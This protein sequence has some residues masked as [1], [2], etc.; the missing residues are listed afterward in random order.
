MLINASE[1][2]TPLNR[3][4][5]SKRK[6]VG[7][8][9]R[10]DIVETLGKYTDNDYARVFDNEHFYF[11]KQAIMLTNIDVNG[12]TF[13]AH[14]PF[15]E[16]KKTGEM[17]RITSVALTPSKISNG[18][19]EL[20]EFVISEFDESQYD[21][22]FDY[23]DQDIKPFVSSLDYIEQP[24]KVTTSEGC[25][26][27]DEDQETLVKENLIKV[28]KEA[29][30]CGKIVI[31]SVYKKATK[32][33]GVRIVITVELTPDYQ[34]DYEVVPFIRDEALNQQAI[35]AFMA[36]YI[37]K[38]FEYLENVVGVELNFNKVFYKPESLCH[39]AEILDEIS[40]LDQEL[41]RLEAK[42]QL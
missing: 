37:T 15:K 20:T 23:F 36:K 11:N 32:K 41:K 13:E 18:E 8:I 3:N 4:K 42:F 5:G 31:K 17:K 22:L 28:T 30:G 40:A 26:Y 29:L 2:S 35:E 14:L 1:K 7:E 12:L 38:P 33:Q 24:L 10:L 25:Y 39:V 9:E 27:F 34:K 21:S 16:D 6:E 19:R